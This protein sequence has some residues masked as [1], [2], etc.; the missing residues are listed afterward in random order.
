MKS[1]SS[2]SGFRSVRAIASTPRSATSARRISLS[3]SFFS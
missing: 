1:T 2:G 3:I